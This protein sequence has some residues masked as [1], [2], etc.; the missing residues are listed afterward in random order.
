MNTA[1]AHCGQVL[2]VENLFVVLKQALNIRG[3][4]GLLEKWVLTQA[5]LQKLLK[6]PIGPV[7]DITGNMLNNEN[8]LS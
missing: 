8:S 7:V 3:L 4:N 5:E 2:V 6:I 1:P